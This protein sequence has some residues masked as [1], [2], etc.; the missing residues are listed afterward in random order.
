MPSKNKQLFFRLPLQRRSKQR[1]SGGTV[2]G[3]EAKQNGGE[4]GDEGAVD[5]G[6]PPDRFFA[7]ISLHENRLL[8]G[9]G[10][11]SLRRSKP[12]SIRPVMRQAGS[13]FR[14]KVFLTA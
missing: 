10:A 1:A 2:A 14:Q 12:V 7:G 8:F 6:R 13:N 4:V 3:L 9:P 11:V 5:S